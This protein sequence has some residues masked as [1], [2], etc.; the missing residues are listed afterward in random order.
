M[1]SRQGGVFSRSDQAAESPRLVS[2]LLVGEFDAVPADRHTMITTTPAVVQDIN[3]GAL[4]DHLEAKSRN[5]G[6]P[7]GTVAQQRLDRID[8]SLGEFVAHGLL[9]FGW[10]G[11]TRMREKR[12]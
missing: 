6:V 1:G 10:K 2:G 8:R 12:P 4:Q 7:E 5:F 9:Q 11:V 3:A